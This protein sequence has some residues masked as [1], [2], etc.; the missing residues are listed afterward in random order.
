LATWASAER[1]S[2]RRP[3]SQPSFTTR[4]DSEMPASV[5][6]EAGN[7]RRSRRAQ[8]AVSRMRPVPTRSEISSDVIRKPDSVKNVDTP[9]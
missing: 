1:T 6:A 7:S 4:A 3:R 8:K 2:P 9:R 5:T